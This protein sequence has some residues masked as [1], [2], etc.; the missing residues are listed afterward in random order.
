L[1]RKSSSG[2][3]FLD[4][5]ADAPDEGQLVDRDVCHPRGGWSG[6]DG[7]TPHAVPG[8]TAERAGGRGA[9]NGRSFNQA[10]YPVYALSPA[11]MPRATSADAS[12][13]ARAWKSRYVMRRSSWITATRSGWTAAVPGGAERQ[14]PS[15]PR[16]DHAGE[17]DRREGMFR[18]E[19]LCPVYALW[20]RRN[21]LMRWEHDHRREPNSARD[22]GRPNMLLQ[23]VI[24]VM[25]EPIGRNDL[26]GL[27]GI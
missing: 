25:P 5:W 16:S 8:E 20:L 21:G 10:L 15:L 13:R 27:L 14:E 17:R 6:S 9:E 7:A 12:R 11:L 19:G 26:A 2:P 18:H 22:F 3:R 1:T 24:A 4:A 23:H